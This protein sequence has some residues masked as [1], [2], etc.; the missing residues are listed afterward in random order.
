MVRNSRRFQSVRD[1]FDEL[2]AGNEEGAAAEGDAEEGPCSRVNEEPL[3]DSGRAAPD[4][5]AR[6]NNMS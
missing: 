6:E 5:R 4:L 3:L 1:F 2:D